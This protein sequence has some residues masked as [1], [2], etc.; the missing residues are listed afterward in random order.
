M[1]AK[2]ISA[3]VEEPGRMALKEFELPELGPE[4]ALLRVE[5]VG[6][7][8]TDP[9]YYH[10]AIAHIQYPVILGHEILGHIFKIGE[11]AARRYG[12]GV[13]DRVVVEASIS[14]GACRYCLVGSYRLCENKR[15]Y[16]SRVPSSEPPHLW[17]AYG[18]YMYISQGSIVHR[19]SPEVPAEAAV[20]ANAVI[21]NGI[22]WV[23]LVGGASMAQAVVVQG[24]GP[25]GLAMTIAAKESGAFPIMITGLSVDQDRFELARE[26]GADYCI[27]VQE[28]DPVDRV[29]EIT[30]GSMADLVVDVTGSPE[31]IQKSVEMVRKQGTLVA[32]GLTGAQTMTPLPMDT[33]VF[34]EIRIQGVLSKGVEAVAAAVKLIE[35]G[36]YP[37]EK[38]VTHRYPLAA[39]EEAV[40]TVGREIPGSYPI[41]AV[42]VP[43]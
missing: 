23:R 30:G 9:K 17:G 43:H 11:A 20:L 19:I 12:V 40:R 8:G 7:C 28:E 1:A 42:L 38:M 36:R 6:V 35:S 21:A 41:K 34:N 14:C 2:E 18:Q 13:G 5:M 24:A 32:A 29:R 27:D 10:G 15:G 31:A 25:Q 22:Q 39:A 3:V 16:G 33:I 26:F 4:E 37:L